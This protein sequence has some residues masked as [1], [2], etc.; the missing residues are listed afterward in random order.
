[1]LI[2]INT[3]SNFEINKLTM[4]TYCMGQSINYE[5]QRAACEFTELP[6]NTCYFTTQSGSEQNFNYA[7]GDQIGS[8]ISEYKLNIHHDKKTITVSSADFPDVKPVTLTEENYRRVICFMV[9][10]IGDRYKKAYTAEA[11]EQES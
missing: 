7:V 6:D 9:I 5:D 3:L 11:I 1:M 10:M 2:N 4:Q 8:F